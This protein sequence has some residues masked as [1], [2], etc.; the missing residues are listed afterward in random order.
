M[1]REGGGEGGAILFVAFRRVPAQ[2][3][4]PLS[5]STLSRFLAGF[6]SLLGDLERKYGGGGKGK[7][8]DDDDDEDDDEEKGR[9]SGSGGRRA[10]KKPA[11]AKKAAAVGSGGVKGK[12]A[13]A[14]RKK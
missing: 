11:P 8:G 12:P 7:G 13:A 2:S 5:L 9:G 4:H 14:P 10:A 1:V 6:G 3:W